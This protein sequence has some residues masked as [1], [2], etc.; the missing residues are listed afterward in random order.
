MASVPETQRNVLF[1]GQIECEEDARGWWLPRA[2][3]ADN[4][5]RCDALCRG[6]AGIMAGS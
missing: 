6:F 4:E 2:M 3:C 5:E 1:S